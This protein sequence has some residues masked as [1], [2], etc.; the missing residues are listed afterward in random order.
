MNPGDKLV[1]KYLT[2]IDKLLWRYPNLNWIASNYW[3]YNENTAELCNSLLIDKL[4]NYFTLFNYFERP[5]HSLSSIC[6]RNRWMDTDKG[7]VHEIVFDPIYSSHTVADMVTKYALLYPE[8]YYNNDPMV[9]HYLTKEN[10][11]DDNG[12]SVMIPA[13]FE[14]SDYV[15]IRDDKSVQKYLDLWSIRTCVENLN[16]KEFY[17]AGHNLDHVSDNY[18]CIKTLLMIC[19]KMKIPIPTYLKK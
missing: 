19:S 11:S 1:Y 5:F 13:V 18:K 9:Y 2:V 14:L 4:Y 16:K 7:R 15:C 10:Q 8:G 17:S 12:K 6:F 3:K